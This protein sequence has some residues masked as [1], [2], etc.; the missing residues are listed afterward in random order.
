MAIGTPDQLGAAADATSSPWSGTTSAPVT[1]GNTAFILFSAIQDSSAGTLSV[2][3]TG[4]LTWAVTQFSEVVG[5]VAHVHACCRAPAPA[6]LAGSTALG[7]TMTGGGSTF[8]GGLTLAQ[9]S[10]LP[11]PPVLE[12]SDFDAADPGSTADW[13]G[14]AGA[15]NVDVAGPALLLATALGDGALT[16]SITDAPASELSDFQDTTNSWNHS[17]AYRLV[18]GA[19]S[20]TIDGNFASAQGFGTST[21]LFAFA[22][23]QWPP[24]GTSD[25]A[26]KIRTVAAQRF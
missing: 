24:D 3:T 2:T 10:G 1:A 19:G 17:T 13:W 6:G 16:T 12:D 8:G 26:E 4:G 7:L 18:S 23:G 11:S 15:R 9:V 14:G 22:D 25:A 20:Y 5:S 21:A